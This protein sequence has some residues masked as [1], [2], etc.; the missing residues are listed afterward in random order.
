MK[1]LG[2]L[3][4]IYL[5]STL[6]CYASKKRV[7]IEETLDEDEIK[8]QSKGLLQDSAIVVLKAF[9]LAIFIVAI[10]YYSIYY[11]L[12]YHFNINIIFPLFFI[13]Q[14]VVAC[15]IDKGMKIGKYLLFV[16]LIPLASSSCNIFSC[17][18]ITLL[19]WM[20]IV[21]F[22]TLAFFHIPKTRKMVEENI[23]KSEDEIKELNKELFNSVKMM[24]IR[25]FIIS[26][27]FIFLFYFLLRNTTDLSIANII[28]YPI[29]LLV[30]FGIAYAFDRGERYISYASVIVATSLILAYIVI[31]GL[32]YLGLRV[33][34]EKT[35]RNKYS[36]ENTYRI[37]IDNYS[38]YNDLD[39]NID[40]LEER[41]R[42]LTP[43][44]SFT[45][46]PNSHLAYK[47]TVIARRQYKYKTK[48]ITF[49]I[50]NNFNKPFVKLRSIFRYWL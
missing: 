21:S 5:I 7:I 44:K 26:L 24:M 46:K 13:V 19:I 41:Y 14:T 38:D 20:I 27:P 16:I 42:L 32:N 6:I 43:K 37:Y 35:I 47:F 15:L 2:W 12:G 36:V 28:I 22:F 33:V 8:T 49:I 17:D 18:Y 4:L 3:F 29:T 45:I 30:V 34:Q 40:V 50:K 9:G 48:K 10:L 23:E 11:I 39:V 25:V 1:F 31:H